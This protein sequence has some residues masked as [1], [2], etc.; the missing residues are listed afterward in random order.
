MAGKLAPVARN[1]L[2]VLFGLSSF[3]R[4]LAG[5]HRFAT[6]QQGTERVWSSIVDPTLPVP[7]GLCFSA[8][9]VRPQRPATPSDSL[10]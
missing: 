7:T 3:V 6:A 2:I 9:N 10:L 8:Q 1:V 4:V 5:L